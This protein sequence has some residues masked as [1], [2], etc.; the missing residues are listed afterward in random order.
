MKKRVRKQKREGKNLWPQKIN[1][2]KDTYPTL[3]GDYLL[4]CYIRHYRN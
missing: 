3:E 2:K 4:S 1:G